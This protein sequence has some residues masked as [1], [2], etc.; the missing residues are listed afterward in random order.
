MTERW[1]DSTSAD[2][3]AGAHRSGTARAFDLPATDI[4][5]GIAVIVELDKF[6]ARSTWAT[7]AKFADHY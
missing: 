5:C 4:N 7:R 2:C 3:H 1:N 6:I